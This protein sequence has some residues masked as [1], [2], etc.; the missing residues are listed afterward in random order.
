M[1]NETLSRGSVSRATPRHLEMDPFLEV[2]DVGK[3]GDQGDSASGIL[4][5]LR[6]ASLWVIT[7]P[8]LDEAMG[9]LHDVQGEVPG[10][11]V[12]QGK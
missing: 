5:D 10:C 11:R 9:I 12:A 8:D 6:E 2:T 3:R 7:S 4:L 1:W